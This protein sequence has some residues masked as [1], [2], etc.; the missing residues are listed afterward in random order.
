MLVIRRSTHNPLLKPVSDHEWELFGAF[1]WCPIQDNHKVH[2]VYRAVSGME[3]VHKQELR[4]SS[5]GYTESADGHHFEKRRQLIAPVFEWEKFGC[6]DPRVT[7]IGNTYYIFYTAL[8]T[9]P[10]AAD[11]IKIAVALTKDFKT[12]EERHLV[13]PFNAKAMTLFPEKI[14]GKYV[15][16]LSAHTDSPPVITAFARFDKLEDMWSEKYWAKWHEHI[17]DHRIDL[18]RG[19][20]DHVEIGAPPIKTKDGW[21]LIYSHIQNYFTEHKIFGIEAL[22]LDLENPEKIIARTPGPLLVPEET[23]EEFGQVPN[24]IFPS[25]AFVSGKKLFIYYGATDTTGC[26][27]NV[28]L[29]D[30]LYSLKKEPIFVRHQDNPILSP[31]EEH[32]WENK[33][34]FN[35]AAIELKGKV[36]IIYR[37]MGTDDTSVMGYAV[38]QNGRDITDRSDQPIYGP[39]EAFE[40]KSHPGNSGCEDPRITELEDKLH[41][42]YTAYDGVNPPVVAATSITTKDFLQQKWNWTVPALVTPVGIDNKDACLFPAKIDGRYLV[43]HRAHNHIC[44]DPIKSLNFSVDKVESFTPIVGPRTGMW[45]SAKVGIAAPPIKTKR[46]WLLFYHGVSDSSIYRVGAVLLQ[47]KDPTILLARTT[48]AIFEPET[49]YEKNGQVNEVVFPCGVV[50]RGGTIYLYYGGGDSVVGVATA[51]LDRI[52]K[53]M[54]V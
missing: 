37:A 42:F 24:V 33:A 34:V 23:Y 38:S 6:E 10:F 39:R 46:G 52:L 28:D 15:A 44:L 53:I 26:R 9:F 8:S 45:D 51:K 48:D 30:L 22:L 27:A 3:Y 29:D 47:L 43:F 19:D 12:V 40:S 31:I 32:L 49:A 14:K 20:N 25:G 7:K 1:N 2:A 5:V 36:H 18:R 50:N 4:I 11:G 17:D 41:M 54:D 35:P 16:M 21:L 13:T